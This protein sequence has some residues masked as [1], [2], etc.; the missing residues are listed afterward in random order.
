LGE[1]NRGHCLA[2]FDGKYPTEIE[3]ALVM[4]GKQ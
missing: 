2:C 1:P 3:D 4:E